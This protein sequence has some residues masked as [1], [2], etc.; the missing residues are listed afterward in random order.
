MK[1]AYGPPTVGRPLALVLVAVALLVAMVVLVAVMV[2]V[3][4][5]VWVLEPVEVVAV[6][7]AP[8]WPP[9]T[10]VGAPPPQ[11]PSA[12]SGVRSNDT[13]HRKETR[14]L[15]MSQSPFASPAFA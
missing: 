12:R 4:V 14:L 1:F 7:L 8:L 6:P 5:V 3:A 11:A 10:L 2:W 15:S 13:A 9:P